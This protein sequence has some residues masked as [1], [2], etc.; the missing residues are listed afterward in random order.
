MV[1]HN[2]RIRSKAAFESDLFA[3]MYV[4][5][6]DLFVPGGCSG[7]VHLCPDSYCMLYGVQM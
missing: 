2:V 6:A 1:V 7:K 5:N 3:A 4:A